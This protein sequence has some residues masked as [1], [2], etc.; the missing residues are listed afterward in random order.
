MC[1]AAKTSRRAKNPCDEKEKAEGGYGR[2]GMS[3]ATCHGDQNA[4]LP[5][6]PPGAKHWRLA[7]KHM[8]WAGQTATELCMQFKDAAPR[9]RKVMGHI[10]RDPEGTCPTWQPDPLVKWGWEPGP[11]REPVP[12][13]FDQ[14]TQILTW[15]MEAGAPC[16]EH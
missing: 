7:P 8:G 16:P 9:I 1:S 2:L 4:P 11:G 14:F 5:G 10:V 6:S 15:W 3:C 13:T 12:G